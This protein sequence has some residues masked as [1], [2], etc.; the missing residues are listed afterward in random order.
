MIKRLRIKFV[1]I[2]MVMM[3]VMLCVILGMLYNFTRNNL[4]TENVSMMKTIA[5]NPFQMGRPGE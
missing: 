4:I 3:T 5:A 1:I 2:N